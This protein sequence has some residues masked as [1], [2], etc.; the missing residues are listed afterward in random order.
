MS[1]PKRASLLLPLATLGLAF[2]G[3]GC[4]GIDTVDFEFRSAPPDNAIVTFEQIRLHEGVAVGVRAI[5]ICGD[6][7]VDEETRIELISRNPGVLGIGPAPASPGDPE[8]DDDDAG[9]WN[10]VLFGASPG[11]TAVTV[12]IDGDPEAD[13]P[14]SVDPQ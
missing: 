12:M 6:E 14:V 4:G 7:P 13:I 1:Y 10:F 8:Y 2:G 3:I 5:A 11:T 9:N